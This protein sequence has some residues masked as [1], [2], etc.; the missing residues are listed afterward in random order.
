MSFKPIVTDHRY[1]FRGGR[2]TAI[3]SDLLNQ[4][5]LVDT[6]NIR[7]DS[8]FGGFTKRTGSQRIH[9]T[10][11][12][13]KIEAC[14]QWDAPS[15]KQIV[16]ISDG[17]FYYRNG[18]DYSTGFT[19]VSPVVPGVVRSTNN[20]TDTAKAWSGGVLGINSQSRTTPGSS[21]VASGSRL[22]CKLGDPN[23]TN[24]SNIPSTDRTY[25]LS[26]FKLTIDTTLVTGSG[27]FFSSSVLW[28]YSVDNGATW[29]PA[30]I[31][32]S[33]V[34]TPEIGV[35]TTTEFGSTTF[36]IPGAALF[37][38]VRAIPTIT[39]QYVGWAGTVTGSFQVYDTV[40]QTD[41]YTFSWVTGA[42]GAQ[43]G[44]PVTF[45]PFRAATSGAPLVLFIASNN[46]YWSWDGITTL[47][48]LDPASSAP[49]AYTIAAYHTR[50]FATTSAQPKHLF[51][52]KIG[53]AT[54][55]ATGTKTDGGSALTDFLTGNAL[56][57]MELIGSSLLLATT[58]AIMRFTG[59][60]SDDIVI[61]QDTEGVSTEVGVV[62]PTAIK[63]Y[64]NTCAFMSS[65]GPY[66]ATETYVQP[67]GEALNP[68][69]YEL[70]T[71]NLNNT[72]IEYN[73]SR[74]ELW[75]AVPRNIDGGL[76]KSI[77]VQSVRLNSWQGPWTYPFGITFLS[78]YT[79]AN[80]SSN[81]LAGCS[82]GFLR[83]MDVQNPTTKVVKDD[84]LY[85]GSGGVPITFTVEIPVIH[86]GIPALKKSLKWILLQADLPIGSSSVFNISFDAGTVVSTSIAPIDTGAQD[87]RVDVSGDNSQGFRPRIILTDSSEYSPTVYGMSI[88]AWNYQRTS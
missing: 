31:A 13:N 73:R 70:D 75:F 79:D 58:E 38:W 82:D 25:T 30:G 80:G 35:L 72:C 40:W 86:F 14:F 66:A 20:G 52:S 22:V 54:N 55:F 12:P 50:M 81:I 11:F 19:Q 39:A 67:I 61:A 10:A 28:E 48:Q 53:D 3:S 78:K 21:T 45:A 24:G 65:R 76:N 32:N 56:I 29:S 47:T 43:L 33:S 16:V 68:D 18:Y 9:P 57:A 69:W 17:K 5:E 15:G 6:T 2:N 74:K 83:L 51:W 60:A 71:A 62:G 63:R 44:S 41:N 42:G 27:G 7:L 36:T 1:D 59:H 84:I 64:E 87:Y 46:H 8:T 34:S 26:G 23:Q 4:N 49:A 77:F 85:D 88:I 37:A